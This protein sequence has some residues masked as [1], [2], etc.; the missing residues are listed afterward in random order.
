M[1]QVLNKRKNKKL[2]TEHTQ[3][4]HLNDLSKQYLF[5]MKTLLKNIKI[6]LMGK[7]LG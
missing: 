6:K 1:L 5:W 7:H 3:N 2:E 4:R